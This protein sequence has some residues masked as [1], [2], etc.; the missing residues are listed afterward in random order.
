MLHTHMLRPSGRNTSTILHLRTGSVPQASMAAP[1]THVRVAIIPG[2][3][4]GD[5]RYSNWYGWLQQALH[6]PPAV[7]CVLRN[8]PD[9]IQAKES[10]W[11]PFMRDKLMCAEDTIIVGHSSGAAAA[12]RFAEQHKVQGTRRCPIIQITCLQMLPKCPLNMLALCLLVCRHS[13]G[14][15]LHK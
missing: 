2:N 6:K 7:E 1:T 10:M 5:V 11:L 8:M 13:P 12:M 4:D 14:I 3:G 9:P 15:G